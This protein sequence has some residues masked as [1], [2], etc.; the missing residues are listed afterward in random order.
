MF[1]ECGARRRSTTIHRRSMAMDMNPTPAACVQVATAH[2]GDWS[3][4]S[5]WDCP[6]IDSVSATLRLM[7]VVV[8]CRRW[9]LLFLVFLLPLWYEL[10]SWYSAPPK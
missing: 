9:L 6:C 8:G 7:V 1:L 4:D 2:L 3:H 5:C 10:C